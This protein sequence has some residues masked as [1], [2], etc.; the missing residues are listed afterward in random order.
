MAMHTEDIVISDDKSLLQL[1]VICGFLARSYWA[2]K[3][4][5]SKIRKSIEN[6]YCYG[7]Y[8]QGRQI[9]FARLV[10]DGATMYWLC[11]VFIDEDFRGF[12][13]GKRL[14]ETITTSEPWNNLMGVLG[15]L[16]A[17]DLYEQYGFS[18]DPERYMRRM[19]D[20]L[21]KKNE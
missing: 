14:V 3:R 10:S 8:Y 16:D 18:R 5:E 7:V 13:I 11:D 19:P 1:D 21:T 2:N 6:S 4:S 20:F 17:H 15:T 9:G 12:G